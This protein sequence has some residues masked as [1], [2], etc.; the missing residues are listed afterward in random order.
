MKN[1]LT[2]TAI[3]EFGT[4]F[5]LV[6]FPGLLTVL[7]FGSSIDTPIALIIA[8]VAGLAIIA[9]GVACWFA[10]NDVQSPATMGLVIAMFIYNSGTSLLFIYAGLSFISL[11]IGLWPVVLFHLA[12]SIWCIIKIQWKN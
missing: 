4:G 8:R 7:L 5:V 2:V 11:G 6:S 1:L 12:M 3:A 9:L 10:R